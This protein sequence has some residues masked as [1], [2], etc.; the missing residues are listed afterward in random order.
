MKTVHLVQWAQQGRKV[1]QEKTEQL[2]LLGRQ[3]HK[4]Q[5]VMLEL[6][7][8]KVRQEKTEQL[9]LSGRQVHKAQQENLVP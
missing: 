3:V 6:Q 5:Q 9:E 7:G 4:V 1:Q 2:E 8:H